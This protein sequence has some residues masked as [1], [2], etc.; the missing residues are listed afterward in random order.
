ME[1]PRMVPG[2]AAAVARNRSQSSTRL[3][4]CHRTDATPPL[5]YCLVVGA[6]ERLAERQSGGCSSEG[7]R[8]GG[9]DI[10]NLP[11]IRGAGDRV[12]VTGSAMGKIKATNK[13]FKDDGVFA[14]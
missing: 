4:V 13:P 5:P 6:R 7:V 8:R 10:P 3:Y 2:I 14:I 9:N 12:L 1:M 11:R